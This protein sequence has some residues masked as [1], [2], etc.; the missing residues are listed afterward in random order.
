MNKGFLEREASTADGTFGTLLCHSRHYDLPLLLHTLELPWRENQR[1]ISCI[2]AGEYAVKARSSARFGLHYI[3]E[4]VPGR[5]GILIHSGNIAGDRASGLSSHVEGCILVGMSRGCI[6]Q[7]AAVLSS[8]VALHRLMT[9]FNNEEFELT[10]RGP[11][12]G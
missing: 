1:N 12:Y 8:K 3:L 5:D 9:F 11:E 7:Q 6:Q 4:N 2:P 10:V